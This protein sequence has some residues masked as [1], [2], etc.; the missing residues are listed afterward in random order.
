MDTNTYKQISENAPHIAEY[1]EVSAKLRAIAKTMVGR[2][3]KELLAL[4]QS[5]ERLPEHLFK[6]SLARAYRLYRE[7]SL[8]SRSAAA[9]ELKVSAATIQQTVLALRAGGV[10]AQLKA[11]QNGGKTQKKLL[12]GKGASYINENLS[13]EERVEEIVAVVE[14]AVA[15]L[16]TEYDWD[17]LLVP[18]KIA[19]LKEKTFESRGVAISSQTLYR[20]WCKDL[21]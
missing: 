12:T 3:Q 16:R 15:E 21:W 4:A 6:P 14:K 13:N 17:N 11:K 5:L 10:S 19:L 7:P 8:G 9:E 1:A 18:Q 2:S 20:E